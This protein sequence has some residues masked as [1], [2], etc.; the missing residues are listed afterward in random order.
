ML[1]AALGGLIL[2]G[3]GVS[4]QPAQHRM[5][6]FDDGSGPQV[7]HFTGP[8]LRE[9]RKPDFE[10][11]DLPVFNTRLDLDEMQRL[12][13]GVL[14]DA[15]LDAFKT[16]AEEALPAPPT[17]MLGMAMGAPQGEGGE[18]PAPESLEGMVRD[19][20][21][22]A[23]GDSDVDIDVSAQGPVAIQIE[24]RAAFGDEGESGGE[25][26]G[27]QTEDIDVVWAEG[28]EGEGEPEAGVYIAVSGPEGVELPE[29]LKEKLA[30]KAQE[31]AERIRQRLEQ[32]EAEGGPPPEGLDAG[33][34]A[35]E[36]R[37]YFDELRRSS[38]KF[39]RA[40]EAL[41]Q[42]FINEV[43]SQLSAEQL[44]LWPGFERALT[45]IK[46]LPH[47]RLDGERTDLLRIIDGFDLDDDQRQAV[48]E[49]MESYELALHEALVARNTFLGEAQ[50]KI[51]RAIEEG[52]F[53]NAISTADRASR[54][55]VAVR[56]VNEQHTETIAGRLGPDTSK[57][58]RSRV[59]LESYPRVYRTTRA[60]KAFRGAA[61]IEGLDDDVRSAIDQLE[62]AYT[63]ELEAAN[64]RLQKAI[65]R[66][67]PREAR[68][69]IEHIQSV[70]EG[71]EPMAVG[72]EDDPIRRAMRKR[73]Q[74]DERY[75]K[76]VYALL[77]PEQVEKLPRLPSQDR[78]GPIVIERAVSE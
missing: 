26:E 14:L 58:F 73:S 42:D 75:M 65:H 74:L 6:V 51:D 19:A 52:R 47:G 70:M 11:K 69:M 2:A 78:R 34:E 1:A 54:L 37:R 18:G 8:D 21:E 29:E 68:Q 27:G 72:E 39:K 10:H 24:A 71:G 38:K 76:Q 33:G 60:Q 50:S 57:A 17:P 7:V 45:R 46:T 66:H 61:R 9:L 15:Y 49:A 44:E 20:I 67:Q 32:I 41:R 5:M 12:I 77:T 55:R 43:R 36:R 31:M 3:S 63:I 23:G 56:G 64:D 53:A 22:E 4:A 59:L 13:V 40:K 28:G 35:D 48:A 25:A 62:A 16:L 30:L